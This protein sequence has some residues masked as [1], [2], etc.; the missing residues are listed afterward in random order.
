MALGIIWCTRSKDFVVV[1]DSLY[2]L[3]EIDSR[4]T[5]N[6]LI[7]KILNEYT[8][9]TNSGMKSVTFCWIPNYVGSRGNERA[10]TAAKTGLDELII[11][12]KFPVSDLLTRVNQLCTREWKQ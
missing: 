3:Q 2:S 12:M 10:D 7:L 9:L 1:S 5:E 6:L 4:K 8:Q 11:D